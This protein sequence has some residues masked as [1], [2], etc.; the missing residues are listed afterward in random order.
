MLRHNDPPRGGCCND[1]SYSTDRGGEAVEENSPLER[2][3]SNDNL[4]ERPEKENALY[5]NDSDNS[6]LDCIYDDLD[7]EPIFKSTVRI[8][9]PSFSLTRRFLLIKVDERILETVLCG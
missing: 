2:L 7:G 5:E 1:V 6:A 3:A 4:D 9:L 8:V